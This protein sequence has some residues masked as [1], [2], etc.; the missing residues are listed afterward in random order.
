MSQKYPDPKIPVR[1]TGISR[2]TP[3]NMLEVTDQIRQVTL[4]LQGVVGPEK[5]RAVRLQEL[6]QTGVVKLSTSGDLVAG[7]VGSTTIINA[8]SDYGRDGEIDC[9]RRVGSDGVIAGGRRV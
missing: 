5:L 8:Q 2:P 1:K 4:E 6:L 9:G 3:K 7:E